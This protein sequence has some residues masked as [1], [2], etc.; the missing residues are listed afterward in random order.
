MI[1][2]PLFEL[3][4]VVM[5]RGAY[6]T[7][8]EAQIISCITRHVFGDFGNLCYEDVK[9]NCEAIIY[10]NRILSSY[11]LPEGKLWIITEADRSYTTC[12]LPEEY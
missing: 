2:E 1:T 3:G 9:T 6:N 8:N 4:Q 5:T 7:F 12:L 11:N 10:G